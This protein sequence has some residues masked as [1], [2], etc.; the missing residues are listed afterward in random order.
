M[1][2]EGWT[3]IGRYVREIDPFARPVAIHPTNI[4]RDQVTDD[5]VLDLNM[6]Q[7]GHGDQDSIPNTIR[8]IVSSYDREPTMPVFNS[9]VCYEGIIGASGARIQRFMFYTCMLSGACG[10]TYGANGIWQFN[11]AG[12]PY[13]ASPSG[14]AWGGDPWDII[15]MRY[16]GSAQ[17]G[18]GKR[19]FERYDWWRMR[20][21][22]DRIEPRW[23]E[24][25]YRASY[26][27][28]VP[29]QVLI[30][31]LPHGW[32]A[33]VHGLDANASLRAYLF[34][35]VDG[36]QIDIAEITPSADGDWETP[37]P[38]VRGD[39]VLVVEEAAGGAAT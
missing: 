16:P 12:D 3:E 28:E 32:P 37:K 34:N 38:P 36:E 25:N 15:C 21:C 22:P 6:L 23:A 26:A 14:W 10:H 33:T 29:G 7:T 11:R 31:Y 19:L 35:P 17:L 4:G 13:G 24:D 5:S 30:C 20:P 27:A 8:S 2:R 9:E 1:Q 18:L 39:W